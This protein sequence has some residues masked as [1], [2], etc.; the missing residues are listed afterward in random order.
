[1]NAGEDF[2]LI[3]NHIVAAARVNYRAALDEAN[4]VP[5]SMLEKMHADMPK[6]YQQ[7]KTSLSLRIQSISGSRS[8]QDAITAHQLFD[9][10]SS[11][12]NR[13]KSSLKIPKGAVAS[14]R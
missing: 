12:F 8:V 2:Q 3:P 1:M 4:A 10:F 14:C 7:Y 5:Q 6:R 9:D 13:N 11:W